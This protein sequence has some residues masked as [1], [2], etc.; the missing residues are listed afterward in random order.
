MSIQNG[1]LT[2]GKLAKQYD[3]NVETIRY[4]QRVGL[5]EAPAKPATGYRRYPPEAGAR[6]GFIRRAQKLG[7]SL[8]E[9]RELLDLGTGRCDNVR[10]LA[11][12][13]RS[14]I[15]AQI[16]GLQSIHDVLDQLI[17]AYN[18]GNGSED[19]AIM[20]RLFAHNAAG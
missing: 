18:D 13:K 3:V 14:I 17:S 16:R 9:V 8:H 19:C 7:F 11:K 10:T 20:D 6:L 2:I 1:S 5:M 12:H 15:A 4:Y